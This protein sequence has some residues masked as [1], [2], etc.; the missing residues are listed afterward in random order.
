MVKVTHEFKTNNR[1][2]T[3]ATV[4]TLAVFKI[5]TKTI[6]HNIIQQNWTDYN[7]TK[8]NESDAGLQ[9][10]TLGKTTMAT[11]MIQIISLKRKEAEEYVENWNISLTPG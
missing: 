6:R 5:A 11:A 10:K 4:L 1:K 3:V 7:Q 2:P 8:E 9:N